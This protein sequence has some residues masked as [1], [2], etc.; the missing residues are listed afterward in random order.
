MV[1]VPLPDEACRREI[2]EMKLS[3]IPHDTTV[4]IGV[5]VDKTDMFSGAEVVAVC[6]NAA[7]SSIAAGRHLDMDMMC[8]AVESVTPQTDEATLLFYEG[9]SKNKL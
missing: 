3:L 6:H 8:R 4:D 7:I 9:F 5:L 2:L 1:H